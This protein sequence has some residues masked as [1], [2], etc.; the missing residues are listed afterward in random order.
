MGALEIVVIIACVLIVAG[1]I[2]LRIIRK[3]Q[4]KS[5]CDC[6]SCPSACNCSRKSASEKTDE[7]N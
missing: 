2:A 5:C 1:V 3:K 7:K 4:G 6:S